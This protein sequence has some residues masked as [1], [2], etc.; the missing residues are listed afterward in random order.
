MFNFSRSSFSWIINST[1]VK[2]PEPAESKSN[3]HFRIS[4]AKSILRIGGCI[5]VLLASGNYQSIITLAA[6]F[7]AAEILGIFEEL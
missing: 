2:M 7:L 5:T 1:Q 6:S 4:L 3:K